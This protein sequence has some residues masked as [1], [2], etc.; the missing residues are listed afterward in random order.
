MNKKIVQ[1]FLTIVAIICAFQVSRTLADFP[2][3]SEYNKPLILDEF[4]FTALYSNDSVHMRWEPYISEGFEY[5]VI[6]RSQ[7]NS[8]LIFPE[9]GYIVQST[10]TGFTSY[11]DEAPPKGTV[12][13]RV[14]SI[15]KPNR[16]C[17]QAAA[18]FSTSGGSSVVKT[19]ATVNPPEITLKGDVKDD[20]VLLKWAI[21]GGNATNGFKILKSSVHSTPL[22]PP[23]K[24][25]TYGFNPDNNDTEKI[26]HRVKPNTT[27]YYRIC[28]YNGD[29]G[30]SA[31][32]NVIKVDVPKD[33]EPLEKYSK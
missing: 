2:E 14:C 22:F 25:D 30:C 10:D 21:S 32:S 17:S 28:L 20:H 8:E 9:D 13:Y 31:Y 26:D 4:K 15:A 19:T 16:F 6:V 27:Y 3:N 11:I 18:V 12:F 24:G 1:I 33:F 29:Y 23:L 7:K 5:Y